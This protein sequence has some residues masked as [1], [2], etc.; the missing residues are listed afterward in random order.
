MIL[1]IIL[2]SVSLS[3]DAFGIGASYGIRNIFIPPATKIVI[4]LMSIAI[5]GISL[6]CGT[7]IAALLPD[8]I[9]K[10]LGVIILIFM[11]LWI[12]RQGTAPD[13]RNENKNQNETLL[14]LIIK[15]MGITIKIIKT[16]QICDLN[17]SNIIEPW[18]AIYLGFALSMDSFGAGIGSGASGLFSP[19]IPFAVALCQIIFLS[20][21]RFIGIKLKV[22]TEIKENTWTVLSGILLIFIGLL[23]IF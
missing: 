12:I 22:F 3:V 8:Y 13:K 17:K 20:S 16:P 4:S 15:S 10:Y 14:N 2:L 18:E 9:A 11:G 21:G 1:P 23:R 5:T 6:L 19:A 7:W